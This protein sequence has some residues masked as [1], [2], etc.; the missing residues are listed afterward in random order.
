VL[1]IIIARWP[2]DH[3]ESNLDL[4]STYLLIALHQ[5][6]ALALPLHLVYLLFLSI[7][8]EEL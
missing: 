1:D 3:Q 4:Y 5:A 2:I 6:F 8:K 7:V